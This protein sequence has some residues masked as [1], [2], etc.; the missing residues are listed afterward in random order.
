MSRDLRPVR[1][2]TSGTDRVCLPPPGLRAM[3]ALFAATVGMPALLAWGSDGNT[4]SPDGKLRLPNMPN[5]EP[6]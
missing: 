5:G 1:F 4:A 2:G 3:R 6:I